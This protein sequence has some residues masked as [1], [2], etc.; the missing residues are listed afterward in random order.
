MEVREIT[1]FKD[2]CVWKTKI[3]GHRWFEFGKG[4]EPYIQFDLNGRTCMYVST[5]TTHLSKSKPL[6]SV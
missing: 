6:D 4:P 3:I 2:D 1:E 5:L